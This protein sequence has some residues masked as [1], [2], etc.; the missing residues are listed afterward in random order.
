MLQ[1][2]TCLCGIE[3]VPPSV[4]GSENG[5]RVDAYLCSC[6]QLITVTITDYLTFVNAVEP[7]VCEKISTPDR[8]SPL[9]SSLE[10][11]EEEE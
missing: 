4:G 10:E 3:L 8:W 6:H 9:T 11:E 7:P 1:L 5:Q 2:I